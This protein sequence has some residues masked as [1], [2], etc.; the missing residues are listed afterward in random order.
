MVPAVARNIAL[1]R[2]DAGARGI[3]RVTNPGHGEGVARA[4]PEFL[5][6]AAGKGQRAGYRA[7]FDTHADARD[8]QPR[9]AV[10][11]YRA[12]QLAH[13]VLRSQYRSW[14]RD[15]RKGKEGRNPGGRDRVGN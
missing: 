13:D 14:N 2:A 4:G 11:E 1:G 12:A 15:S 7:R 6:R 9:G 5:W 10:S 8:D 3:H